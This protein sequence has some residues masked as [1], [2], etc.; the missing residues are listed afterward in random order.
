[1][2]KAI[3]WTVENVFWALFLA[4]SISA[5]M[6]DKEWGSS[7]TY[8]FGHI[9]SFLVGLLGESAFPWVS[10]ALLGVAI[11]VFLHKLIIWVLAAL[12]KREKQFQK[13]SSLWNDAAD[14]IHAT[15]GMSGYREGSEH[16]EANVH[17]L[18]SE[19]R[20]VRVATPDFSAHSQGNY[21]EVAKSYIMFI[22][23]YLKD[24]D[25]NTLRS[26]AKSWLERGL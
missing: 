18:F 20:N 26:V 12:T 19:L 21:V 8:L 25:I 15:G 6:N 24:R 22:R 3:F 14:S 7:A 23:P 17:R 16:L 4:P 1:M 11:G 2:K 9:Y 10:G 5:W 13:L